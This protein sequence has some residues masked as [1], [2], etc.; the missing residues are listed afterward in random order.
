VACCYKNL[1]VGEDF[2]ILRLTGDTSENPMTS[3]LVFRT[4]IQGLE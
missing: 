4:V 1:G 2:E 3:G